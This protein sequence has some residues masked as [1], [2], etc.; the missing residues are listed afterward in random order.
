[1]NRGRLILPHQQQECLNSLKSKYNCTY[2]Q[3][4]L[5]W[6]ISKDS[7]IAVTKTNSFDH[8]KECV[9]AISKVI[10][11]DEDSRLI[12]AQFKKEVE[13]V[14]LF[15]IDADAI[16]DR[17]VYASKEEALNNVYDWIPSP[18]ILAANIESGNI[19]PLR[20][21]Q[22][23]GK[24]NK[25]QYRIDGYD[26]IGEMKKYWGWIIARGKEKPIP[27]YIQEDL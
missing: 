21:I 25:Y 17:R 5:S 12:E 24:N 1:L 4:V 14:N 26:F 7:L 8:L 3:L 23:K 10:L 27:S 15:D 18:E 2:A 22:N 9:D 13:S 19:K 20:L 6:I 11:T 16:D